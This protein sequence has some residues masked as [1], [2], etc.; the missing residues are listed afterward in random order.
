M[1]FHEERRTT[2]SR[3]IAIMLKNYLGDILNMIKVL[4]ENE[5]D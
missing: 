2:S 5:N 1:G 3:E 4:I